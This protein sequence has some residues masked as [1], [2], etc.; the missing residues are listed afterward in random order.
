MNQSIKQSLVMSIFALLPLS[1][2]APAE[3]SEMKSTKVL[4]GRVVTI[5][6]VNTKK[7]LENWDY[8]GWNGKKI[9]QN[10]C[11]SN[12][13][14]K[15]QLHF[16]DNEGGMYVIRPEAGSDT[17][18]DVTH[19]GEVLGVQLWKYNEVN[20]NQLWAI[21]ESGVNRF[22]LR[23]VALPKK[24]LG[25]SKDK[26]DDLTQLEILDCSPT[27]GQMWTIEK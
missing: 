20:R 19:E 27:N 22:I 25:F 23:S 12:K 7:C 4:G 16:K 8:G 14:Q 18:I 15:W 9:I 2:K 13:T 6:N 5:K 26:T 24:C 11:K 10:A 21:V 1:C 3:N 17:V